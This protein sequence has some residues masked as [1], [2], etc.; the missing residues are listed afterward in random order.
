MS[1][2]RGCGRGGA[3]RR[4]RTRARGTRKVKRL[5]CLQ[6]SDDLGGLQ[7]GGLLLLPEGGE[8][9]SARRQEIL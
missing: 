5:L 1:V 2:H 7:R 9:A 6:G 3:G 4:R 8:A